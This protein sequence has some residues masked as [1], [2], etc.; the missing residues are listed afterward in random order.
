MFKL[1][2]CLCFVFIILLMSNA[3]AFS[4]KANLVFLNWPDYIHP[5]VISSFEKEF[6]VDIT[7][8]YYKTDELKEEMLLANHTKGF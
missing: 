6:S 7:P 2:R 4:K 1:F 5:A 3:V 8:V